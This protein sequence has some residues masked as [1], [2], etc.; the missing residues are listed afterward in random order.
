LSE[1]P[2]LALPFDQYQRYRLVADLLEQLR[3]ERD[4]LVV[5]DVG[6]RTALLRT[7]L[8]GDRIHLVDVEESE[9]PG[10]VLG[11][12][13]K[14]PFGDST[15]DAVVTIDTLEHVPPAGRASFVAECARVARRWVVI[16]GPFATEGVA[17]AEERL[18]SFVGEK[19]GIVHRYLNEHHEHGLPSLEETEDELRSAGG[20]VRS[21]GHANLERWLALMCLSMY[22]DRD[23]PLRA[24]A[25]EFFRFYNVALYG[26][27]QTPPV[28]RHAVVAALDGSSLPELEVTSREA[29]APPESFE[30]IG[31]LVRELVGFDLERDVVK[32]EWARLEGVNRDLV[33]DLE[34]HEATLAECRE[35]R[36]EQVGVIE[37][38]RAREGELLGNEKELEAEI[39]RERAESGEAITGLE[40]DLGEH[41][42]A[43]G[44]AEEELRAHQELLPVLNGQ[45]EEQ[46]A[47]L[48]RRG[49]E[50]ASQRAE[51]EYVHAELAGEIQDL[52]AD[53]EA[54]GAELVER[55][56]ELTRQRVEFES[57]HTELAEEI[58]NLHAEIEARGKEMERLGRELAEERE[59]I[60]RLRVELA[61][62]WKNLRRV[63]GKKRRL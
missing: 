54:Q 50:M 37:E 3:G 27:D 5:L 47:E 18:G 53:L 34:Q 29:V 44:A 40:A 57:V 59:L 56:A 12:G 35:I 61:S 24:I 7:F 23:A 20:V 38:L 43:L 30:T 2:N 39:E 17:E 60:A 25:P 22:I 26:L 52:Q 9:E 19:L 45:L 15:V 51:L 10:L 11:D 1:D 55:G 46:A 28:Y 6:G 63:F 8:E 42:R 32:R 16:A 31:H 13:A 4:S 41:R 14:L 49:E 48:V 33:T 36:D 62:R 58:R 21:V